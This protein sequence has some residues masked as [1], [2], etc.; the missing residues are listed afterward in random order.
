MIILELSYRAAPSYRSSQL[1]RNILTGD[2]Q[3]PEWNLK[4]IIANNYYTSL[5]LL[6]ITKQGSFAQLLKLPA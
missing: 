5:L 1:P 4:S 3:V 6:A 2:N